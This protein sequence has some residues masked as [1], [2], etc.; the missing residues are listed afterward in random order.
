MLLLAWLAGLTTLAL[1]SQGQISHLTGPTLTGTED[2]VYGTRVSAAGDVNH[3]GFD[4]VLVYGFSVVPDVHNG[5]V[6]LHSGFDGSTLHTFTGVGNHPFE[7]IPMAGVGD[8]DGDGHADLLIGNGADHLATL[9]SGSSFAELSTFHGSVTD[10]GFGGS[11]ASAGDVNADG[12]PDLAVGV[13]G[14]ALSGLPRFVNVYSGADFSLLFSILEESAHDGFGAALGCAGDVNGDGHDDLLVGAFG[15][16]I[17][18]LDPGF[19]PFVPPFWKENRAGA[20][21]VHSGL[22]GTLLWIR[23]GDAQYDG[24]GWSVAGVGDVNG[25]DIPDVMAGTRSGER[26]SVGYARIHSG[27]D[28]A[29]LR[30]FPAPC[31]S[32]QILSVSGAGDLDRDGVPDV[33]VAHFGCLPSEALHAYSGFDGSTLLS[34]P[35]IIANFGPL[36]VSGLGDVN[37]DG[38]PDFVAGV[39]ENHYGGGFAQL[40]VSHDAEGHVAEYGCGVN[41]AGSLVVLGGSPAIGQ[42]ITLALTDPTGTAAGNAIAFLLVSS[43]PA[44]AYPCG[45]IKPG[46]GLGEPDAAG[47]LLIGVVAP[48]PLLVLDAGVWTGS[49]LQLELSIPAVSGLVG[50]S[51]HLQGA[52]VGSSHDIGL[53]SALRLIIG[54][55]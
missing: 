23:Y 35:G 31:E 45:T 14:V 19:P 29:T 16:G 9:Y 50:A 25:D 49:P 33:L 48:D 42:A 39:P 4:D 24:S 1:V 22:D 8:V 11:V 37:G 44:P 17:D 26:G 13:T 10:D 54:V 27:A 41:P 5:V 6:R 28:G 15:D 34:Y 43:R 40:F 51:I 55:P 52:L 30:T 32:S 46:W 21:S 47:E 53:T 20:V 2:E 7:G 38:T 12:T 36:T 18:V 3:D